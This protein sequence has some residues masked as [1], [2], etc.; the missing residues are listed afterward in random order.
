MDN[1]VEVVVL[2]LHEDVGEVCLF[3]DESLASS[4]SSSEW[5]RCSLGLRSSASGALM[6]SVSAVD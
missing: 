5:R 6:Q 2:G 3:T 1:D 4:A